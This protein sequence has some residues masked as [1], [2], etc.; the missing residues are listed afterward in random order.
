MAWW[1]SLKVARVA[2]VDSGPPEVGAALDLLTMSWQ[3]EEF[4]AYLRDERRVSPHTLR[5]YEREVAAFTAFCRAEMNITSPAETTQGAL[6]AYL[7]H[8]YSR[9]LARASIQRALAAVRTYFRFLQRENVVGVNPARALAGPR[10]AS[11]LPDVLTVPETASLLEALPD[12]AAGRRDRAAL[13]LLYGAGLRAAELVGLDLDDVDVQRRLVR[14]KGKGGK[15]RVVPF[16]RSA[17]AALT[18][19]LPERARW[20][21]KARE[22]GA[23]EPLFVNQRGGRLSDRSLRRIV[24]DAV[25]R[26]A[27]L[28]RVH[29]HTLRHAFATHLLEAGMDLPAI[30]ELLGHASLATTQKYTHLDLAHLMDTYR[31][32]H[33]KA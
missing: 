4:S 22:S 17:A 31:R 26:A 32:S 23:G 14:V 15:E 24:D 25:R 3:L 16:G 6:R 2:R 18:T 29:P 12:T 19:Y 8:L 9:R 21:G 28:R 20:R 1:P 13:E 30:Q 11:T 10:T 5:A 33:P 27:T 7:A